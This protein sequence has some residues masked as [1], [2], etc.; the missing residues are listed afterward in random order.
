MN[1]FGMFCD[2]AA[3]CDRGGMVMTRIALVIVL[4]WIGIPKALR[5][6]QDLS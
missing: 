6:V 3:K 2:V 1:R 4:V 5:Q